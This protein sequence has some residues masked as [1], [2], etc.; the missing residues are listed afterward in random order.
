MEVFV[1]AERFLQM[2]GYTRADLQAVRRGY[3]GLSERARPGKTAIADFWT[4]RVLKGS[5]GFLRRTVLAIPSTR[6]ST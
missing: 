3:S 4:W 6:E 2:L 5:L 1:A